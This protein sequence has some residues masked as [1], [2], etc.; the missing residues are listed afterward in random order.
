M[1]TEVKYCC[2]SEFNQELT[3]FS[4]NHIPDGTTMKG[5]DSR[6]VERLNLK[7]MDSWRF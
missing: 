6:S 3:A 7:Q 2:F 5:T 4:E 1:L